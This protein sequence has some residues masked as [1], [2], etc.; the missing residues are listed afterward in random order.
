MPQKAI[1]GQ[2]M[3]DFLA[4]HPVSESSKLYEDLADEV[5]EACAT[6]EVIRGGHIILRGYSLIEP[7][8]NNVAEYNALLLRIQLA[9]ELNIRHLETYGDS[10]LIV[11]QVQG[12]Y[13]ARNDDLVPYHFTVLELAQ[14]FEGF[15]IEY[16]PEAQNTY[17][18]ALASLATY[19]ALPPKEETMI[20]VIGRDLYHPK[21]PLEHCSNETIVEI[22]CAILIELESRDW[23]FLYI[24]YVLYMILPDDA[25]E[26]AAI[27]RKALR[28]Y[29]DTVSQTLYHKLHDGVLL[30]Y[31]SRREAQEDLRE[32][33]D[34]MCG[35][36]QPGVKLGDCLR[37]IGYYCPKKFSDAVDYA[38][39]C[40]ACQI[41]S[42]FIHQALGNL[43]LTSASWLFEMRGMDIVGP[44]TL[45]MA[46]GYR[47]I[48]VVTDYFSKWTEPIPL[49]E[50][51]ASN[52]IKFI[53]HH[54][55]YRFGVPRRIVHDDG[56]QFVSHGF[57]RFYDKFRIQSIASMT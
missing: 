34:R 52:V 50:V 30:C 5:A 43:H 17:T 44:I 28:F 37:R 31:L 54:V 9:E 40:H 13:K 10:Q 51:K 33:H 47:F 12:E 27:K 7:C 35:A 15:F 57:Q 48:L 56:T 20:F 18:D 41:H 45:L 22:A 42:D 8:T 53:K 25:K 21:I 14:K 19:L 29:Y 1:K 55:I 36:H 26:A 46:K 32:A 38:K 11:N 39:H 2:A 23:R 3:V 6:Q 49:K 24:D 16:I 4:D